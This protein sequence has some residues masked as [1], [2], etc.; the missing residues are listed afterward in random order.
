MPHY[1]SIQSVLALAG[2]A[3]LTGCVSPDSPL[4][5]DA[6]EGCDELYQSSDYEGL[7]V[8][9]DVRAIMYASADFSAAADKAKQDVVTACAAI[10]TDLGAQ[11]TWSAIEDIGPQISNEDGTGACDKAAAQIEAL[12]APGGQVNANIAVAVARGECHIDWDR[13][14]E[15]DK[16]CT[17]QQTC[18][19]GS[20]ET[21]CEPAHI[22]VQCEA[23]CQAGATCVGTPELPA[24]CMG[25]CESEC[26]GQCDGECLDSTTGEKTEND[27]N[28][29]GKCASSCNGTCRGLCKVDEPAGVSCGANVYCTGGCSGS[30][31]SP[32]CT[33]EVTPPN[34]ELD[35]VCYDACTARVTATPVCT[36]T[37]VHVYITTDSPELEPLVATLQKNLPALID[38]AEKDGKLALDA[39]KRLVGAGANLKGQVDDLNG[40]SVACLG[41]ASASAA[42]SLDDINVSVDASARITVMLQGKTL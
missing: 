22:S 9:S 19:S 31:T 26:V 15:C 25:K 13:Q 20:I 41:E 7:D 33:T 39:G 32:Q 34:C 6:S 29:H 8:D 18:D 40:K 24:N 37:T 27:P 38:A 21:R 28:C 10:A 30:Y 4:L 3:L 14:V 35:T 1:P 2:A 16:R 12:V 23:A 42:D 36:P 17:T 11:D 5:E